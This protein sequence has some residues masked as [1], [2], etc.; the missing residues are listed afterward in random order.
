[1]EMM[2][3][4]ESI[5][6]ASLVFSPHP[7]LASA[8]RRVIYTP[9]MPG[10]SI[11]QYLDHVG[12]NLASMPVVLTL[13][14][15]VI[16]REEW[17]LTFPQ[18][19]AMIAIRATVHNGDGGGS[20]IGRMVATIAVMIAAYYTGG[21]AASAYGGLAGAA[22]SAV[23]TVA[24]M[25]LVNSLYPPPQPNLSRAAGDNASP[26]YSIS[27]SRNRIRQF[28]PL[29]LLFGAHRIYPD[30]GA[31][32]YSEFI[33]GEQYLYMVFNFG[34][35]KYLQLSDFKI[36]D[37]PIGR[38]K[39]VNMW[40]SGADGRVPN[41]PGNVDSEAP[42]VSLT[43][44][45]GWH[46]RTTSENTTQIAVDLS[47]QLFYSGSSGLTNRTARFEVEY[48]KVGDAT[49]LPAVESTITKEN[50]HYWS[51][52]KWVESWV[53]TY[54]SQ[55]DYGDNDPSSHVEGSGSGVFWRWREYDEIC[56][57]DYCRVAAPPR[58]YHL[59][60]SEAVI[61]SKSRTPV[62]RTYKWD[63]DEGQ[64]EVRLR[65]LSADETDEKA[66]SEFTWAQ[67]R[68][69]QPDEADYTGQTRVGVRIR[70]SG[71]L[72]GVIDEFN[73]IGESRV[74]AWN[75]SE[76][77]ETPTSN[78]AWAFLEMARGAF[79][80]D[81]N[82]LYGGGLPDS[83][84]DIETIKEWADWCDL[85]GLT[86]DAVLDR[87]MSV[88]EALVTISQCG[89]AAT[90]RQ[91]G[92]LGVV[93]DAEDLPVTGMFGMPNIKAG[94]FKIE[95]V[96]DALADEI[97]VKF[98][99]PD[100]GYRPDRVRV[101]V[102]DVASPQRPQEIEL[103]GCTSKSMAGKIANLMAARQAY[104]RQRIS[105]E[106]DI[107]GLVVDRGNVAVLSHD[108]TQWSYSGRLVPDA[109]LSDSH[110]VLDR[111]VPFT[112]GETHYIMIRKPNGA[113]ET[114]AVN[115]VSGE[116]SEL[117]L[118]STTLS[119]N[120]ASD[121][122][123]DWVWFFG[124]QA[125]P[126]KK[127]KIVG[128]KPLNENLV[129]LTAVPEVPE[130]YDAEVSGFTYTAPTL[131]TELTPTL[132]NLACSEELLDN[133][134]LTRVYVTWTTRNASGVK[135]L[136]SIDAQPP[137]EF[138][139]AGNEWFIDLKG[140]Q[141]ISIEARPTSLAN[142][143]T[144]ESQS[145]DYF[146]EGLTAWPASVENFAISRKKDWLR[147]Y[148]SQLTEI[149]IRWYEIRR[150]L[151]WENST[152]IAVAVAPPL[153]IQS[154]QAG[155][156]LIKAVDT[157]GRKS[158]VASSVTISS[159]ADI[160]IVITTDEAAGGW[161][162]TLTNM[163]ITTDGVELAGTKPLSEFTEPLS[164][165]SQSLTYDSDISLTG[166]YETSA[167]NI[168][169]VLTARIEIDAVIKQKSIAGALSTWNQPLSYYSRENGWSLG[170]P[171]GI[172]SSSIEINTSSDGGTT[173]DGWREYVPG[174]YTMDTFK[175]R[176]NVETQDKGYSALI[177]TL[178]AVVDV[179]DKVAVFN[180][181]PIPAGGTTRL[182]FPHKFI[183]IP[184]ITFSLQD[185]TE[186]D[187]V[188]ISNTTKEYTDVIIENG[189]ISVSGTV[190]L[191][192]RGYY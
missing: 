125:T 19:N 113:M 23:V 77:A 132:T 114:H 99:N 52:G 111:K 158:K 191:E 100:L 72:N 41:F 107:E 144:I 20:N 28:E 124:P 152:A 39:D 172:V 82:L 190:D 43:N 62:R 16:P 2:Q 38:Y 137:Q 123:V 93:W 49:W 161:G 139:V 105:W 1:M 68:S 170:G 134:G 104:H 18:G 13:N 169:D 73:A 96:S 3:P 10:Q 115:Y 64:Y 157:G 29:P 89:R 164:A 9:P 126:G 162:G 184:S 130:Y 51:Y 47:G 127:V 149:D 40:V 181:E 148:W 122:P 86:F 32:P 155:T 163:K 80:G 53:G 165:Y 166:S 119:A 174:D 45:S 102:P 117:D 4:I 25:A 176:V 55:Y 145:I 189:G 66:V 14:G 60:V 44:A 120:P 35:T 70:A 11:A 98:I 50:T 79:D 71:Q 84:I 17:A 154:A 106:T 168:G 21:A 116:T 103:F 69:Y 87:K 27:G 131:P 101:T 92:V 146:V 61:T 129:R 78:P 188:T 58:R 36:G 138:S 67:M 54:W 182:Y 22:A 24:G 118:T 140:G 76:F 175:I 179:E 159:T 30:L 34:I 110:L 135:L 90:T 65:R 46:T 167:T 153:T 5:R 151:T 85:H 128:V 178:K 48:R 180:K 171:L 142:L 136:V 91:A 59:R 121:E 83:R 12:L 192:A 97:I 147:F 112:E 15:E 63:V 88:E 150:G 33:G 143:S 156:Y 74:P 56:D 37:T 26:T 6:Q 186:G 185:G 81:G 108:L 8:D 160:N 177:E 187:S 173:W 141:T 31:Q 57:G 7:L 42:G 75:G 94:S 109:A 183:E 95:Y 133:T